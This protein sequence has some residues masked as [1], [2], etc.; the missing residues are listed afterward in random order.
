[1]T[2]EAL[3]KTIDHAL[4]QPT[5]LDKDFDAGC[6][7]ALKYSVAALCVKSVD[8]PRAVKRRG[9][10]PVAICAVVGFPHGNAPV[11]VTAYEAVTAMEAG[12][13]EID[14]VLS[15]SRALS[16]D[17]AATTDQVVALN[18]C[19]TERGGL[20]KVIF[21][22]GLIA[23]AATKI[24]LCEICKQ[25][26]V[27][28][29]KTSTGF[30]TM[31]RSDGALQAVGATVA[32]V[33]LMVEHAGPTCRVKASGGIRTRE[34][35]ELYLALGATRIGTASTADILGSFR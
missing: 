2:P 31:K 13:T 8:V 27:A 3:A 23:D 25:A 17:F 30:A 19:V 1:V 16:G 34:E 26:N 33:R 35:V 28:F 14:V 15:L 20:L 29:V 22:T 5:L 21:E 11:K 12:A 4:L 32:D 18:G 6:D 10:S 9:S 24:R 7:V